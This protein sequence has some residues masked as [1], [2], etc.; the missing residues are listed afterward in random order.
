MA[1]S[2]SWAD[3]G[4]SSS[5]S[6]CSLHIER[7]VT[8]NLTEL[9]TLAKGTSTDGNDLAWPGVEKRSIRKMWLKQKVAD[10]LLKNFE[11]HP[12]PTKHSSG[13]EFLFIR[14]RDRGK[15]NQV[16]L[17][18]LNILQPSIKSVFT[19]TLVQSAFFTSWEWRI[20]GWWLEWQT[21]NLAHC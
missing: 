19:S 15:L 10:Q 8:L 9:M 16:N 11:N 3:R 1:K 21:C 17:T 7:N 20:Y 2:W 13:S 12:I 18:S 14:D 6:Q 4:R 5:G